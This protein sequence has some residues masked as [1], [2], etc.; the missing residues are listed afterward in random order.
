MA[1]QNA[2]VHLNA[3]GGCSAE[4]CSL[5]RCS[6]RREDE[7]C[8]LHRATILAFC[9]LGRASQIIN[10][11]GITV[12]RSGCILYLGLALSAGRLRLRLRYSIQCTRTPLRPAVPFQRYIWVSLCSSLLCRTEPEPLHLYGAPARH[13]PL[14]RSGCADQRQQQRQSSSLQLAAGDFL[15]SINMTS[16]W[17]QTFQQLLM[18]HVLLQKALPLI[19]VGT[20]TRF[21]SRHL[22]QAAAARPNATC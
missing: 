17:N 22:L 19:C 2:F 20:A 1:A 5:H 11:L 16:V 9:L 14:Q 15:W 10:M 7:A 18:H 21:L 4:V 12:L 3:R 13:G 6:K 8:R